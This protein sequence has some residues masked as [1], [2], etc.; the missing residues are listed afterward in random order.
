MDSSLVVVDEW[1]S[2][3]AYGGGCLSRFDCIYIYIYTC[4]ISGHLSYHIMVVKTQS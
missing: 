2:Y 4:F 3:G 1:L